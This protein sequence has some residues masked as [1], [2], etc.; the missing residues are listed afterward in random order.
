MPARFMAGSARSMI[1]LIGLPS[2]T[3]TKTLG[4]RGISPSRL[5]RHEPLDTFSKSPASG[6]DTF[7]ADVPSAYAS[8][9][10]PPRQFLVARRDYAHL[11]VRA[12]CSD[13]DFL[14]PAPHPI[15]HQ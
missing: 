8:T 7:V 4:Y 13:Q 15:P 14:A 3:C 1:S 5:G 2:E 12:R 9:A 10:D 11:V 6:W